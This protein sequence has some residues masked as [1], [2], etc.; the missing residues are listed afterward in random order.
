ML[1]EHSLGTAAKPSQSILVKNQKFFFGALIVALAIGYLVATSL[2]NT[3]VY[4]LTIPELRARPASAA[5]IVRVN[6]K[7]V[8]GTISQTGSGQGVRF[9]MHDEK[10]AATSMVV[11]Y[12]GLIPDTFQDNADV[13]VEGK[14]NASGEFD[15]VTLLAKCP[16]KFT[17]DGNT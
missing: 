7:V 17:A 4:Y 9:V 15:A 3:A 14:L 6:G 2:Q 13:V 10:D 8:N 16:S 5:E 1:G 11:S 12:K